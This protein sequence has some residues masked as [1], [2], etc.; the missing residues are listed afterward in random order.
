MGN[1][2]LWQQK[3]MKASIPAF[4][5]PVATVAWALGYA[6]VVSA[7]PITCGSEQRTATFDSAERC[8]T[9]S[10]NPGAGTILAEYPSDAWSEV[11]EI[12]GADGVTGLLTDGFLTVNLVSGSWGAE[13]IQAT[14][15]IASSFWSTYSEAVFSIH[16]G[17]G[18]GDPDYFAWL[19]TPGATS[20]TW[21]YDSRFGGGGLSNAKLWGR[22]VAVPEPTALTLLGMG[23][24]GLAIARRRRK[25]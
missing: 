25:Q 17:N 24:A 1:N 19:V 4:L 9:G 6:S 5:M 13:P 7:A 11:G 16:V 21:S 3:K 12:E 20:G 8:E 15:A 22:G 2:C 18:N 14:W 23:L 10:G